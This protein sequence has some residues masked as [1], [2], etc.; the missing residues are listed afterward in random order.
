MNI[1]LLTLTITLIL[2]SN[3]ISFCSNNDKEKFQSKLIFKDVLPS[4]DWL[5]EDIDQ[6]VKNIHLG[7]DYSVFKEIMKGVHLIHQ[8][9]LLSD[10][11]KIIASPLIYQYKL[12][13]STT[14]TF[15]LEFYFNSEK[16]L[17]KVKIYYQINNTKN[18]SIDPDVLYQS[19]IAS[20]KKLGEPK[21]SNHYIVRPKTKNLKES[22][23]RLV[24][25]MDKDYY[26]ILY[27]TPPD[28]LYR[29]DFKITTIIC[30]KAKSLFPDTVNSIDKEL[31]QTK[32]V[33]YLN[34]AREIMIRNKQ[35]E[36]IKA[37][38]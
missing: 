24:W 14:S 15:V 12:K 6:R 16:K 7:M 8:W 30:K 21:S 4:Y 3:L 29:N 25:D 1:N 38:N 17:D 28:E 13:L 33:E 10:D 35:E 11:D 36:Q 9:G 18:I 27:F 23:V 26:L 20:L 32:H 5:Q 19:I 31:H 37:E 34:R 22:L 2:I